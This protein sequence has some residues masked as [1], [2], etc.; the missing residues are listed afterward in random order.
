M[1]CTEKGLLLAE[2]TTNNLGEFY[3]EFAAQDDLRLFIWVTSRELIRIGLAN[4]QT[5]TDLERNAGR[6]D[7]G[8]S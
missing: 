4:L 5:K 1:V 2:G 6:A 7:A 8:N 3:L